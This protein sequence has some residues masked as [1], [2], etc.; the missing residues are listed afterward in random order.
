MDREQ[1]A[2]ITDEK[3]RFDEAE[4][5]ELGGR[6]SGTADW[7]AQR[8]ELGLP[9]LKRPKYT[10]QTSSLPP[11]RLS[12]I[13]L[14]RT[15]RSNLT[16]PLSDYHI[17]GQAR[18]QG[19]S[20]LLTDGNSQT[21]GIFLPTPISQDQDFRCRLAFRLSASQGG[22]ADGIALVFSPEKKL[23]LGGYG[24]GYTDMGGQGDFAIESGSS[25]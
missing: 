19:S 13:R 9:E 21:S 22:E 6:T 16:Q 15:V 2:W 14:I 5:D 11:F 4:K 20:I 23:G 12:L 10:G 17:S 8:Q 24:L 1:N 25:S 3:K 18:H 7:R